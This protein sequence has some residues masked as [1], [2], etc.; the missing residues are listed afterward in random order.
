MLGTP[1]RFSRTQITIEKSGIGA[2]SIS[3]ES[4]N[5]RMEMARGSRTQWS[6]KQRNNRLMEWVL[7]SITVLYLWVLWVIVTCSDATT[8][9]GEPRGLQ[10][11]CVAIVRN[12]GYSYQ[13]IGAA[14][15]RLISVFCHHLNRS[16]YGPPPSRTNQT[17]EFSLE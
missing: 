14:A 1:S 11:P 2:M 9:V 6:A 13:L 5:P 17:E 16:S 7:V 8:S 12:P 3:T 10:R 4:P 15:V